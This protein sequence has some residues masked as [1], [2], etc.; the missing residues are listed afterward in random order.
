MTKHHHGLYVS[1]ALIIFI[2]HLAF[3]MENNDSH[4]LYIPKKEFTKVLSD[5]ISGP[6]KTE[7]STID[8]NNYFDDDE[9]DDNKFFDVSNNN[10]LNYRKT[11]KTTN[12][13]NNSST[14]VA[15]SPRTLETQRLQVSNSLQQLNEKLKIKK[16]R[17]IKSDSLYYLQKSMESREG[18]YKQTD[19]SHLSSSYL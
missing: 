14:I 13:N 4:I 2:C 12:K 19:N 1:I 9:D 3:N 10:D 8:N 17:F 7:S 18:T 11:K 16:K 5:I 6:N 15:E